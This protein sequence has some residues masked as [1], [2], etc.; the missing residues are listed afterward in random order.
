MGTTATMLRLLPAL[1]QARRWIDATLA[2]HASRAQRVEAFG[3]DRLRSYY[4]PR[5]LAD[6]KAVVVDELPRPPVEAWGVSDAVQFSTLNAGGI[7]FKDTFFV[8]RGC[9][10]SETLFFH[11]LA[12]VLQWRRLGVNR[13]LALYGLGLLQ[14]D[15][16]NSPLERMAFAL[17]ARFEKGEAFDAERAAMDETDRFAADFRGSSLLAR[18]LWCGLRWL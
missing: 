8:R 18:G 5:L 16:F 10:D 1:R 14:H 11:E 13:F 6:A 2:V 17:Q 9:E 4:S 15:Y 12:H 3:F 7:T